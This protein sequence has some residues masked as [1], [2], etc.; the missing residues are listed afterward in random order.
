M[1]KASEFEQIQ[2]STETARNGES[3]LLMSGCVE[4]YDGDNEVTGSKRKIC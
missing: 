4:T 2:S 3:N 1:A